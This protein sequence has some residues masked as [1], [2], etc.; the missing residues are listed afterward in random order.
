MDIRR[1]NINKISL[2][3]GGLDGCFAYIFRIKE[4]FRFSDIFFGII[5]RRVDSFGEHIYT[6]TSCHWIS[7]QK[8]NVSLKIT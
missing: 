7:W 3:S 1:S 6:H 4:V 2:K 8:S 5:D